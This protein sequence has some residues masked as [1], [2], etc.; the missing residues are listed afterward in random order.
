MERLF[1]LFK[2]ALFRNVEVGD[3]VGDLGKGV[4][5]P[6]EM[7]DKEDMSD[8]FRRAM[9]EKMNLV[10]EIFLWVETRGRKEFCVLYR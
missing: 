1:S 2:I 3:G 10:G 4:G 8:M 9:F 6:F 5:E 7:L